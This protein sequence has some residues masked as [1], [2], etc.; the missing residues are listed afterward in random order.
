MDPVIFKASFPRPFIASIAFLTRFS[1][2]QLCKVG[3]SITKIGDFGP[4]KVNSIF[5]KSGIEDRYRIA[6][7]STMSFFSNMGSEPI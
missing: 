1:M 5:L 4:S 3:L 2:V 6:F 7:S